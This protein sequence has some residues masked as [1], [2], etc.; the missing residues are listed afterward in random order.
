MIHRTQPI[1]LTENWQDE[2]S[3]LITT[4]ESLFDYLELDH[5]YLPAAQKA[6]QLFP[7]RT[8]RSYASRIEKGNIN[9]PLLQQVLPI[10]S[11]FDNIEGFS[12][13]PLNEKASNNHP[14][15][16]HKYHGRV[17]LI[18][19]PQC[20]INCRYCFRRH[21]DYKGNTPSR[22]QWQQAIDYIEKDNTI[23]EVILSGGDPLVLGDTQLSWLIDNL[24]KIPHLT[25]LRLHSRLPIVLPSRIS[26][27][28]TRILTKSRLKPVFVVHCNHPQEID[29]RVGHALEKLSQEG[30]QVFN[31]TVLLKG[32]N[33]NDSTL[34]QLSKKLFAHR[35][36]PY[37]L[38]LLD[39]VAGAA[40]FDV[41]EQKARDLH[42]AMLAKLPGYLVPKLVREIALAANKVP[43]V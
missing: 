1:N 36:I 31:Q 12:H 40:H 24:A 41:E 30:I 16:I 33:D 5:Q 37:Y 11:E 28:L 17:L 3:N 43:I 39:K 7:T 23:N 2:L 8:T 13:D 26:P 10:G 21:F 34:T 6:H 29:N 4:P 25:T 14:G 9:D 22:Q 20:A 38:H 15:L 35:T 32:I 42:Q 19:A 27:R 18:T